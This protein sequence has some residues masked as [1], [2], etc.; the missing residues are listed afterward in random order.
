[1]FPPLADGG[2][3]TRVDLMDWLDD[4]LALRLRLVPLSDSRTGMPFSL[5]D[6]EGARSRMSSGRDAEGGL[7][8]ES[9]LSQTSQAGRA[10][11]TDLHAQLGVGLRAVDELDRVL[12]SVTPDPPSLRRCK[13]AL[14]AIAG[15]VEQA[16]RAFGGPVPEAHD[17]PSPEAGHASYAPGAGIQSRGEAYLRLT[18]AADYLLRTEPH[19]PVPYLIMRAVSWGNMSL[20]ELLH[21]FVG[22]ADNLVAIQVLLG[23]RKKSDRD[24]R[25]RGFWRP[26]DP[27]YH[28]PH[29]E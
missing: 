23:M 15:V 20:A 22:G 6:W 26:L 12:A 9:V 24:P 28:S 2:A 4:A 11:W 19:S 5:T 16:I 14:T 8:W 10:H 27:W 18:E 1:M 13:A 3:E 25:S 29:L 21:E 17:A 7:T